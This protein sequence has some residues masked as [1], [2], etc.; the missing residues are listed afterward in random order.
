M[1]SLV[2]IASKGAAIEMRE[3][4]VQILGSW[5][6]KKKSCTL[7]KPPSLAK[8]LKRKTP[9]NIPLSTC[10]LWMSEGKM[11]SYIAV[12]KICNIWP[13]PMI[14]RVINVKPWKTFLAK[15]RPLISLFIHCNCSCSKCSWIS[16]FCNS[17]QNRYFCWSQSNRLSNLVPHELTSKGNL[18][19]AN[20]LTS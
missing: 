17:F 14:I 9:S 10:H 4:W 5:N 20:A 15:S 1:W 8:R 18:F 11:W 7:A 6:F 2:Q 16:D 13:F 3:S 19:F 12:F